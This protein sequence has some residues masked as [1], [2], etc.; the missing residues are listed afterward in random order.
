MA[1]NK[2]WGPAGF[3]HQSILCLAVLHAED[4]S[5]RRWLKFDLFCL[6]F[7]LYSARLEMVVLMFVLMGIE[8]FWQSSLGQLELVA[9]QVEVCPIPQ[10]GTK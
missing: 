2:L 10:T 7:P 9:E 1:L 5:K 4:F 8:V 6:L 3:L